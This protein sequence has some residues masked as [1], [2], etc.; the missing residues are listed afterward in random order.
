VVTKIGWGFL[1]KDL[2]LRREDAKE[3]GRKKKSVPH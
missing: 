1:G 2:T 3:G